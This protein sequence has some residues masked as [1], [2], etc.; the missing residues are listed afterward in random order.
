ML[1]DQN[2]SVGPLERG[3]GRTDIHARRMLAVLAEQGKS[4][5]IA[6]LLVTQLD[7]ADPLG[8][9]LGTAVTGQTMFLSAGIDALCAALCAFA[10]IDQHAPANSGGDGLIGG[11]CLSDLMQEHTGCDQAGYRGSRATEK[12]AA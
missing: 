11:T 10:G 5:R 4:L 9:G 1:V 2:D 6:G 7:L 8:I 12:A 3:A